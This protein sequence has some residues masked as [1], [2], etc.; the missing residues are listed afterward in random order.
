MAARV[1]DE[2]V[3]RILVRTSYSPRKLPE[4]LVYGAGLPVIWRGNPL[5][6]VLNRPLSSPSLP[7]M[8]RLRLW[9]Q[10]V[11]KGLRVSLMS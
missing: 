3:L 11:E 8:S 1:G 4:A 5:G 9:P 10:R 7:Y 6:R 2:P